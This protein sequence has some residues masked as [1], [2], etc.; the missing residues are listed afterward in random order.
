[1][2]HQTGHVAC[3][4]AVKVMSSS[5]HLFTFPFVTV[6]LTVSIAN[7]QAANRCSLSTG[8][9]HPPFSILPSY[10]LMCTLHIGQGDYIEV[11]LEYKLLGG[12]P[13]PFQLRSSTS[14]RDTQTRTTAKFPTAKRPGQVAPC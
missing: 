8:R 12:Q 14:Y 4:L 11:L 13:D 9:L 1:M 2:K 7:R 3:E 5:V 6:L 10:R